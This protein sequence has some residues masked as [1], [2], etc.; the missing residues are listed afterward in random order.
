[1]AKKLYKYEG[2]SIVVT[3]DARRCIHAEECIHGLPGVFEKDRRPWI[4]PSLGSADEI[5]TVVARCPTGALDLERSDGGLALAPPQ[6]NTVTVAKDGPLYATGDIKIAT[7]AGA[8]RETR[9][10]FCRCGASKNKPYCDNG[11]REI[12]FAD[13]GTLG[14]GRLVPA[15]GEV[16]DP[17]VV[18]NAAPSGPLL[19]AG[20]LTVLSADGATS[21]SGVKGALCRCGA[22]DKK[23]FCDGT[24]K[25]IGFEAE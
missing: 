17:T 22:S 6:E 14:E 19:V 15:E 13:A 3:Y 18:F 12:G 10:A 9:V 4:D 5:A 16:P 8:Q 21:S 7:P 25:A 11:H 1:M 24:H 20:P 2:E 23:P